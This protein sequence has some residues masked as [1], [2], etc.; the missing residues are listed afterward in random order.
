MLQCQTAW[1]PSLATSVLLSPPPH[2]QCPATLAPLLL[3]ANAAGS[4]ALPHCARRSAGGATVLSCSAATWPR[5]TC[6]ST[7]PATWRTNSTPS[8]R[9]R[10]GDMQDNEWCVHWCDF[11]DSS[12]NG[13]HIINKWCLIVKITIYLEHIHS[14]NSDRWYIFQMV[15]ISLPLH[16]A[17]LNSHL[18]L[19]RYYVDIRSIPLKHWLSFSV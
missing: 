3:Q 8:G 12:R 14:N 10:R 16:L 1:A 18:T 9:V 2:N 6:L 4:V 7:R 17:N 13:V 15:R 5:K 19:V 11:R